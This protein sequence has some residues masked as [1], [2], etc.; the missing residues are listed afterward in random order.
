MSFLERFELE[1]LHV[2]YNH[3]GSVDYI[4]LFAIGAIGTILLIFSLEMYTSHFEHGNSSECTLYRTRYLDTQEQAP[5][6]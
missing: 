2:H 1:R 5:K 3:E 4:D 6:L